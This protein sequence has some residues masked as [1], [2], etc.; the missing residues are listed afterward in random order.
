MGIYPVGSLLRVDT[1]E[2][3]MV[4]NP[5]DELT[6][7]VIVPVKDAGGSEIAGHHPQDLD[8][9]SIVELLLPEQAG[10]D[11]AALAPSSLDD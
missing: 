11:P 3:V 9:S 2:I 5:G 7:P 4:V 6:P 10:V 8:V 1:G